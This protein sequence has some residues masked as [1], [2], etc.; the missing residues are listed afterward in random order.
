MAQFIGREKE[1]STLGELLNKKSASLVVI[2]G[3]R[4]IGKS[5]LVEE[6]AKHYPFEAFY[7]FGGLP[8]T[9][10]T[11]AQSQREVFAGQLLSQFGTGLD[12]HSDWATLFL[13]LAKAM[14]KGRVLLLF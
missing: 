3:R 1:L 2:R 8:P 4:R 11:T 5:R 14:K 10:E 9:P 6:L 7:R 12:L 13:L